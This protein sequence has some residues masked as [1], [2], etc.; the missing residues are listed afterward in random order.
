MLTLPLLAAAILA[1]AP[2]DT[3]WWRSDAGTVIG[4]HSSGGLTCTLT[5][6]GGSTEARFVWSS[7]LPTRAVIQNPSWR[8][9]PG[10]FLNLAVQIGPAWLG[11]G[12]GAPNI[13]ALTGPSSLMFVAADGVD[14]L[15]RQA[16]RLRVAAPVPDAEIVVSAGKMEALIAGLE[17]CRRHIPAA[18]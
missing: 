16:R 18:G 14:D 8:F 17:R 5:L 3:V 7:G 10:S 11:G 13:P 6:D 12:N 15:L 2:A 1:A 9:Q 4:H